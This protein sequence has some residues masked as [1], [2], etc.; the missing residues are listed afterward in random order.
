MSNQRGKLITCDRCGKTVFLKELSAKERD[1]DGGYTRWNEYKYENPQ[2]GWT[3]QYFGDY[4]T[5]YDLCPA[6]T[7][8]LE[9]ARKMFFET[10][11]N[12]MVGRKD[13]KT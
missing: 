10:K 11:E 3:N 9:E 6:C 5:N 4:K 1:T 12:E 13:E 8:K 7:K 2:E